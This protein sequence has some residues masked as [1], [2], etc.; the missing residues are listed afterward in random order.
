VRR[1]AGPRT[2]AHTAAAAGP[3]PAIWVALLLALAVVIGVLVSL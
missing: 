3:H 1:I 2:L